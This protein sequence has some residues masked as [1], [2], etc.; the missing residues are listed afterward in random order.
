M[1]DLLKAEFLRLVSRR[2]SWILLALVLV[3]GAGLAIGASG[4]AR[5]IDSTD[6]DDARAQYAQMQQSWDAEFCNEPPYPCGAEEDLVVEDFL[7]I[8]RDYD[9]LMQEAL[10]GGLLVL[11]A[12]TVLA[13]ALVGGEFSSGSLS[14]QLT[15]TPRRLPVMAAKVA[16]STAAAVGLMFAYVVAVMVAGTMAFLM[17]RG[18]AEVQ[19]GADVP[20]L[21]GRLLVTAFFLALLAASLTFGLGSTG[22]TLAAG[23]LLVVGSAALVT[24]ANDIPDLVVRLMPSLNLF[25]LVDGQHVFTIW[26]ANGVMREVEFTYWW[27]LGYATALVVLVATVSAVVFRRR[28]L[29]R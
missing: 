2:L 20:L 25:A 1:T 3:L 13:S 15:F 24:E 12:A 7:R 9:D 16:A 10:G 14:T 6:W 22:L 28:D 26:P 5:P 21:I 19:A 18:G 4:Q 23:V 8:P 29:L 27:A 17:L 11:I